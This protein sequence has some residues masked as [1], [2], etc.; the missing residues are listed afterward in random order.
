METGRL[1]NLS[2]CRH[3]SP[4]NSCFSVECFAGSMKLIGQFCRHVIFC[5]TQVELSVVGEYRADGD[6][7]GRRALKP[8]QSQAKINIPSLYILIFSRTTRPRTPYKSYH[9]RHLF[10]YPILI[11]F[12]SRPRLAGKFVIMLPSAISDSPF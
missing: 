9:R 6:E 12:F 2:G 11:L 8:F 10:F 3:Q 5:K 1:N 4:V 7:L